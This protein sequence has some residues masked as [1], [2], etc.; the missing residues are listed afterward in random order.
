M[1]DYIR[2]KPKPL[3]EANSVWMKLYED[4][5]RGELITLETDVSTLSLRDLQVV[6]DAKKRFEACMK[7]INPA[8]EFQG[9]YLGLPL[10]LY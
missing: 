1:N 8:F 4:I 2:N 9:K 6:S 5:L 10:S 7:K 3:H